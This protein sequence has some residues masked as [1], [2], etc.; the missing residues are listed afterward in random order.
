MY[1]VKLG[2]TQ[3]PDRRRGQDMTRSRPQKLESPQ[4][5]V[6]ATDAEYIDW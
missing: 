4:A 5:K 1:K 2:D 3:R 6:P